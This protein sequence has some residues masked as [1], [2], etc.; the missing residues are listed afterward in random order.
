MPT[1]P[2]LLTTGR[3]EHQRLTS[4]I[5]SMADGVI[6]IDR[7]LKIVVYNGA[8]L[9]I[10]DLNSSMQGKA[11]DSVFKPMDKKSKPIDLVEYIEK[12]KTPRVDRDLRL[13]Y[14]DSSIINIF[15]SVTPVYRGYGEGGQDG[16]VLV[17]RDITRE[18]SLEEERDEFISVVS[19]EL[20]TPIA[21]A[22][23]NVSNA[24]YIAAKT[25]DITS[26]KKALESAHEQIMFLAAMMN[27][28]STL[29]RAER[30]KLSVEVSAINV[31][32]LVSEIIDSYKPEAEAK[33]LKLSTE[34]APSLE[35]L[36]SSKLYV[37]EVL[38]N[39]ITNALKYTHEGGVTLGAKPKD[40][41][42]LFTVTDTGIGIGKG[43]QTRLF[44]KFFRSE[45]FRTRSTN[46]TGLG[47]YVSKKLANLLHAT[48]TIEST[49]NHGSTFSIWIPDAS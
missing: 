15:L 26:I 10:L 49:L 19:H 35:I 29:S 9:N 36:H 11:I 43:D 47:L 13:A 46:G 3:L 28:L 7:K 20:R 17:L 37:R 34:L 22:E 45:D 12:V 41:G 42:V 48:I 39:F 2:H 44:E 25:A 1:R 23:G 24:Q 33:G 27:D 30:G 31:H 18:K 8:A 16:Y 4:L 5:N 14:G 38:Q 21:I 40:K 6:A 32:T